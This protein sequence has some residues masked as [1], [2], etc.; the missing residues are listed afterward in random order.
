MCGIVGYVGYGMEHGELQTLLEAATQLL[1]HR[2]P[3]QSNLFI[4]HYAGL[5]VSRLAIRD[6]QLG[7]QPMQ[8]EDGTVL[9][10]NG[11]LYSTETIR[12]QLI[13]MGYHFRTASDTEVL[14]YGYLAWG[15][16]ILE[17]MTG[18]FAFAI[19][20]PRRR[21][22]LLAR[23]RWGEKPLYIVQNADSVIF[24]S[25]AKALRPWPG[26]NWTIQLDDI[27]AFLR[28]GYLPDVRT[29]WSGVR[30]LLP[31]MKLV[32]EDGRTSI[33]PYVNNPLPAEL[34]GP[35]PCLESAAREL[36]TL[37]EQA[38]YKCLVSDRPIGAMLSGG[39]DSS[40]IVGLMS[41][42][43][44]SVR[45]YS[46]RWQEMDYT[47]ESYAREVAHQFRTTHTEILCTPDY[48]CANFDNIVSTF[49]E[50]FGDEGMIPMALV[51]EAAKKDVDVVLSGD[52]G[53]E[54]F[55]GYERYH[56]GH[57]FEDYVNVYA[58]TRDTVMRDLLSEDIVRMNVHDQTHARY[59]AQVKHL[60]LISALRWID[61]HT[62]LPSQV[63]T[64]VDRMTMRVA[65]ESRAPLLD[66]AIS[67][68]ALLCD[69]RLISAKG[70]PKRVLRAA[71]SDLLPARILSRPKM[72]FGVP[73]VHWFRGPLR[74][75]MDERLFHGSLWAVGWLRPEAVQ[76]LVNE[77][78]QMRHNHYRTLFNLLVLESWLARQAEA[79]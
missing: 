48:L 61:L 29:G 44:G 14:L 46:I 78:Q 8:A 11:E 60:E 34:Q 76:R 40:T 20:E 2:G 57:P 17:R 75:W 71:V 16:E 66:P 45:T 9:A 3:D 49:D 42:M 27:D 67:N 1:K 5:S 55:G 52:G 10:F 4:D 77:H 72:G 24:A 69:P 53:D 65:L 22:L 59:F 30:K 68:W 73:L 63:L 41:Q 74:Q 79:V 15:D 62:Y 26:V 6:P 28:H 19:W 70:L 32:W 51:A 43:I 25:E 23:D 35:E 58:A 39:I 36:R 50:P 21:R 13:R 33:Q 54:L 56:N 47:E 37:L 12:D 38:V 31:G 7:L 64:K 18:M